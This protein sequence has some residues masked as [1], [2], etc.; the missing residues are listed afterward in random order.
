MDIAFVLFRIVEYDNY[1]LCEM[2]LEM[3]ALHAE[4]ATCET[5]RE[6]LLKACLYLLPLWRY[7]LSKFIK[8]QKQMT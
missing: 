2:H 6:N 4:L 8:L 1:M 5:L 7:D 3:I